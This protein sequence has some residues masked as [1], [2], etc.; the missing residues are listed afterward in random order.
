[1][2]EYEHILSIMRGMTTVMERSP[3]AFRTTN[4][5]GIR[6]HFLVQLNG[7]Y[8]GQATGETFNYEGKTDILIRV[9][10]KNIFIAEC[11]LWDGPKSLSDAIDQLLGYATWRDTKTAILVFSRKRSFS[12]VVEK[13][14]EVVQAHP[15]FKRSLSY[16]H[17]TGVRAV[18]SS[19]DDP[20]RELT[21]TAMAFDIPS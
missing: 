21:L 15:N 19:R 4:E 10:D 18:L 14:P 5:E 2:E 20:N 1:M 9:E 8:Q 3:N 16:G 13:L 17:E 7:I 12:R 6:Q 11:K